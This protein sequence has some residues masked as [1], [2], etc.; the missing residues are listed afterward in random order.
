MIA[1]WYYLGPR[2]PSADDFDD[3]PTANLA[4]LMAELEP[5]A[6]A[7]RPNIVILLADDLGWGDV[8]FHGS[9]IA[10]PYIDS[11]AREGMRLEQFY[12]QPIC[13]PTRAALM[14]G[15]DPIRLGMANAGIM[16]WNPGGLSPEERMMPEALRDAGYDTAM[17]GK[18][19]L[20]HTTQLQTPNG[21]GFRHFF[22]HLNTQ[23]DFFDHSFAGGH[24]L[25]ENGVPV[26]A[27]GQY[28]TDLHGEQ[29]ARYLTDL[30]DKTKPF[31]LYVPFTAP[32]SPMQAKSGDLGAYPRRLDLPGRSQ[33]SYAAMTDSMDQAIGRILT[34]LEREGV[35]DN[36]IV[37]FF[38]DNGGFTNFGA[39]NAPFRGGKTETFEGG[40]RVPAVI[41]WP[42]ILPKGTVNDAVF[43]VMDLF[44]TFA[45]LTGTDIAEAKPLDG[46]DRSDALSGRGEKWRGAPLIFTSNSPIYNRFMHGIRDDNWKLV[47]TI[48]HQRRS[49]EVETLLFNLAT[50]SFESAS[51]AAEY[52]EVVARLTAAMDERLAQHPVGGVYVQLAPHPGWRA[53][54][55]YAEAIIDAEK[56]EPETHAGFGPRANENLQRLYGEKGRINYE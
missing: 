56:I 26:Q 6:G 37:L 49:T 42:G 54:K 5:R 28:A 21:R 36:T 19:H 38:S 29:A 18:W 4:S 7:D 35:A 8:G 12:V 53:P 47:Q 34:T 3:T 24:D 16:P 25:Q 2:A 9:D 44:P 15:R 31:F 43:S 46:I 41:R 27:E 14:T 50:D 17:I 39:Q 32:H 51:V 45:R 1:S 22:G 40:L 10:T 33:R 55:D 48:D 20:G 30:R 23:V 13:T 52:P 11:L